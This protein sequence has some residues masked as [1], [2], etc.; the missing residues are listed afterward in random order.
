MAVHSSL[1]NGFEEVIYQRALEIEIIDQRLSFAREQEM[2]IYYKGHQIGSRRVDFLIENAVCVELKAIS[3]LG[4]IHL[5]QAIN[6]LE[7]YDL[8]VRLLINFGA[9]SLQFKRV[10]P[11]PLHRSQ[12][13]ALPH[14][15]PTS[16][17]D[18]KS[19]QGIGMTDAGR[20]QPSGDE[21]IHPVPADT[22]LV[23]TPCECPVPEPPYLERKSASAGL[24]MGTP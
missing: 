3:R 14:W 13:A 7:A 6:Y 4:D 2:P 5:A 8:E 22:T 15:A 24:F 16:G 21:P 20:R 18:A 19:P 23:A 9:R 11:D 10:A 17:D 1:G 12:R